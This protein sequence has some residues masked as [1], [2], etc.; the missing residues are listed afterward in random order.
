[1]EADLVVN[2]LNL[3]RSDV[4]NENLVNYDTMDSSKEV[5]LAES[6]DDIQGLDQGFHIRVLE[7]IEEDIKE[8]WFNKL[9]EKNKKRSKKL[10]KKLKLR[11]AKPHKSKQQIGEVVK[12]SLS[13]GDVR[14]RNRIGKTLGISFG[15]DDSVVLE[16]LSFPPKHQ[17]QHM[18]ILQWLFKV[19]HEQGGQSSTTPK[20]QEDKPKDIIL[21]KNRSRRATNKKF[22]PFISVCDRDVAKACFY[23]SIYLRRAGKS[24]GRQHWSQSMKM[25]KG[26]INVAQK[27]DLGSHGGN[28]VLPL[29]EA[30]L[31]SSSS[32]CTNTND[33]CSTSSDKK[34]KTKTMSRMKELLRWAAAAKSE[35]GGNFIGRK[36]MQLR[37][38][39]ALKAVGAGDDNDQ[40]SN[41]S[42]KISFRWDVESSTSSS[43]FSGIP[44][45]S[46]VKNIDQVCKMKIVSLNSNPVHGL[47]RCS[48]RRGNWITTDS[49]FVVLEL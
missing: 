36:V 21:S 42:P 3:L 23:S 11:R 34:D 15:F 4:A 32:T 16:N 46:S 39:G 43:V 24:Q 7:D 40:F 9:L 30:A 6:N 17:R 35:K 25:K 38:R 26:E 48:S 10:S 28:K 13:D 37:N 14:N 2:N 47:N 20:D 18:Q 5:F 45:A 44:A 22:K 1:M 8:D 19:A 29:S 31:S 41:E 12:D 33:R 49:E 27:S